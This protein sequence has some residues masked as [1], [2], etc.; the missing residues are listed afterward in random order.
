M[1]EYRFYFIKHD[2]HID[3]PPLGYEAPDD[4]MALVKAKQLVDG[5]DI[6]IWEGPRLVAY[7]VPDNG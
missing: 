7:V 1:P 5:H 4:H 3:R 2:G 6:E